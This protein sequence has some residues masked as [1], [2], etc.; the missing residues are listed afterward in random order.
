MTR[1]ID[2]ECLIV[3]TKYQAQLMQFSIDIRGTMQRDDIYFKRID[4]EHLFGFGLTVLNKHRAIWIGIPTTRRQY[5]C[6]NELIAQYN[7]HRRNLDGTNKVFQFISLI[8]TMLDDCESVASNWS[9][10]SSD[11]TQSYSLI[12]HDEL[13]ASC[14]SIECILNRRLLIQTIET[15]SCELQIKDRDL[16]I[17]TLHMNMAMTEKNGIIADMQR[18]LEKANNHISHLETQLAD[19]LSNQSEWV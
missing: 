15:K 11:T 18:R 5:F 14:G 2:R 4:L 8:N 7:E 6:Y 3:P 12:D 1:Y 17:T 19:A 16:T 9:D 13:S 10:N